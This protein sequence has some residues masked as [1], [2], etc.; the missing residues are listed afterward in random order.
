MNYPHSYPQ[1]P[2]IPPQLF[3]PFGMAFKGTDFFVSNPKLWIQPLLWTALLIA[4]TAALTFLSTSWM[5]PEWDGKIWSYVLDL[6]KALGV[7]IGVLL[8]CWTLVL[9]MA[10]ALVYEGLVRSVFRMLGSRVIE[11]KLHKA[12][13]SRLIFIIK[14]IGWRLL[15]PVAG[16]LGSLFFGPLGVFVSNFGFGHIAAMD[17]LDLALSLKGIPGNERAKYISRQS[18]DVF[19]VGMG[20][21]LLSFVLSIT[22]VGWI[23]YYPSVYTGAAI[24]AASLPDGHWEQLKLSLSAPFPRP[25][26]DPP[27]MMT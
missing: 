1:Q 8:V 2:Q 12:V 6:L 24:W 16:L 21:G 13:L 26:G 3:P 27:G 19:N 9:P 23:L 14:T 4:L 5:W 22:I 15:W 17:S 18:G 20:C 7:G 10:F 25:S 11:E